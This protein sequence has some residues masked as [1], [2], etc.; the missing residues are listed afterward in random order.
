MKYKI[1]YTVSTTSVPRIIYVRGRDITDALYTAVFLDK[2]N[3]ISIK[4]IKQV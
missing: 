1:K 2:V 4:S 3:P